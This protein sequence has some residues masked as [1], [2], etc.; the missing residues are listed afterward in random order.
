MQLAKK[1]KVSD[2]LSSEDIKELLKLS[3]LKAIIEILHTWGWI[4]FAFFI[5]ALWP[6]PVVII[7][8]LFILGGKQ[9]GCAII[10]H[11]SSH[12]ALVKSK[13]LNIIIGNLFGGFPIF[14]NINDYRPYHLDHHNHTGQENDPDLNLTIGYPATT[15]SMFRKIFRDLSGLTGIK[16]FFGLIA[17]HT[18]ILKYTLSGVVIKDKSKRSLISSIIYSIK[19]LAGPILTNAGI[20]GILYLSGY[21]W[22]YF[23]WIG[24]HLTTYNFSI[25]IRS[26]A[27]HSVVQNQLN[28]YTNVRTTYANIFER[29]LFAPHNVNYH[30]EHH[31]LMTVPSYNL[32]KMHSILKGKGFYN[33]GLLQYNY[34]YI[35]KLST[36]KV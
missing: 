35:F 3:D 6:N 33:K 8:S 1:I 25:R 18:G 22:L 4:S 17:M 12:Y 10:L 16:S 32:P 24:A 20:W 36:S 29:I 7:I 23:L 13:K 2:W 21:A 30:A 27:E 14:H 26:I 5:S 28:N 34:W 9:L 11:D 19:N 31:L 15:W